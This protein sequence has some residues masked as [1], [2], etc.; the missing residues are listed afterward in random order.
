MTK[1]D[2][3]LFTSPD[4]DNLGDCPQCSSALMIKYG[5]T[6]AFI[7]CSDYPSCCYTKP[8]NDG[9]NDVQTV[10]VMNGSECP[11]CSSELVIKKGRYGLFIGCSKF[12]TCQHM[13]SLKQQSDDSV[14]CPKCETGRVVKR[15]SRFGKAFFACNNYPKCKYAVNHP[16][17]AKVCKACQFPLMVKKHTARGDILQCPEKSCQHKHALDTDSA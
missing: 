10:K 6:G 14:C 12:P 5:R 4:S 11:L 7:G 13:Q 9:D 2:A 1:I 17:V 8:V 16:P 15:V 3:S